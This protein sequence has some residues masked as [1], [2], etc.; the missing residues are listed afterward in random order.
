MAASDASYID[1]TSKV[2]VVT[3]LTLYLWIILQ[4]NFA[5]LNYFEKGS[6]TGIG[7]ETAL[8]LARR[9]KFHNNIN[10]LIQC[11]KLI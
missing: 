6:N 10:Y 11:D 2:V 9:G 3:G 5:F 7:F 4:R 1:L 8:D